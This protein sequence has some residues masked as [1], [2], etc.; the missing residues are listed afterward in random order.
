MA[1]IAWNTLHTRVYERGVDRVVLYP[2]GAPGI[3]WSGVTQIDE[4]Y[5]QTT[6][7]PQYFEG[8]KVSES[9]QKGEFQAKITAYSVPDEFAPMEGLFE[10]APGLF[11][12]NQVRI[13]FGMSYRTL[14]GDP[15][16]GLELG[17]KIHFVYGALAFPEARTYQ[18]LSDVDNPVLR[19]WQL[20]CVPYFKHE[21]VWFRATEGS[22]L[23]KHQNPMFPPVSHIVVSSRSTSP[24]TLS[25]L[26]DVIYGTDS[27]EP[28]MP[29]PPELIEI[30]RQT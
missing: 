17:Y 3:P 12:G 7:T 13:P 14:L 21:Y 6:L 4:V 29:T 18:S 28:E 5:N 15:T 16:S 10:A 24:Q 2:S 11:A 1:A 22:L 30:V 19:A 27:T 23:V 9:I 25:Y 26:E 8:R 20:V